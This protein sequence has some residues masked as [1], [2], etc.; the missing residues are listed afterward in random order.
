MK[1]YRPY[2]SSFPELLIPLPM[3]F[4]GHFP[5][6]RGGVETLV[7]QVLLEQSQ[8]ITGIIQFHG[9]HGKGVPQPMRTDVMDSASFRI[10]Q[11]WQASS[12]SA[13]AHDL[14]GPVAINAKNQLLP[15]LNDRA[16]VAQ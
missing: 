3:F 6:L 5:I 2:T 15:I 7:A 14:P 9:V 13:L 11:F 10:L 12:F 16:T 1:R 4:P 8:P